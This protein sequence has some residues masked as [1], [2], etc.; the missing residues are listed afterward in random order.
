MTNDDFDLGLR[1]LLRDA[2]GNLVD[3]REIYQRI[4]QMV[5]GLRAQGLPVPDELLRLER[6]LERE[7][8]GDR[9]P[10]PQG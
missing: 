9:E 5:A 6:T 10:P 4:R 8:A 3:R 1:M 2:E 7:F